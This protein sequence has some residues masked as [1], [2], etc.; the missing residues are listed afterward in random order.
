MNIESI[1]KAL[2]HFENDE[3]VNAKEILQKEIHT[4][5]NEWLKNKL[6]LK[7]DID[8]EPKSGE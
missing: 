2:D 5:K 1:K 6:G 8:I 3:F 4:H 7:N